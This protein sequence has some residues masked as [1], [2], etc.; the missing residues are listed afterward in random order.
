MTEPT[1]DGLVNQL[2]V[3]SYREKEKLIK[4]I[5]GIKH[6]RKVVVFENMLVGLLYYQKSDKKIV[7]VKK[8]EEAYQL[9]DALTGQDLGMA[10]SST[11]K[12]VKVNNKLSQ[13]RT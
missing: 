1:F 3:R 11:V 6:E 8:G 4:A 12:K 9:T 2:H 7:I 10:E 13:C 5:G